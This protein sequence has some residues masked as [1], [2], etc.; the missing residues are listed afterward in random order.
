MYRQPRNYKEVVRMLKKCKQHWLT[1]E[2]HI[3]KFN[4]K[5]KTKKKKLTGFISD[6][7]SENLILNNIEFRRGTRRFILDTWNRAD[8]SFIIWIT[9]SNNMGQ[10]LLWLCSFSQAKPRS[11]LQHWDK[12][13]IEPTFSN[14]LE[15]TVVII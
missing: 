5:L 10:I 8:S 2:N 6:T 1:A 4:M 12:S 9:V 11:K 15:G 3:I 7:S 13:S 14:R